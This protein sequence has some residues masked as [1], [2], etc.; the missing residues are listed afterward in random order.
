MLAKT[1]LPG[2]SICICS[3]TRHSFIS[4]RPHHW[5]GA[6]NCPFEMGWSEQAS[7]GLGARPRKS[8]GLWW[9]WKRHWDAE[10]I[11]L[12]QSRISVW[13][14]LVAETLLSRQKLGRILFQHWIYLTADISQSG[15]HSFDY[16]LK[17]WFPLQQ[18]A[19]GVH[20]ANAV[21]LT[22]KAADVGTASNDEDGVALAI[23]E[24]ILKPRGLSLESEIWWYIL[25]LMTVDLYRHHGLRLGIV[26]E[27]CLT[28]ANGVGV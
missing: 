25:W 6:A 11:H 12:A 26:K 19:I 28:V 23:E 17:C 13:V 22:M 14:I 7:G 9:W 16:H 10:G 2:V 8:Y 4:L 15:W 3:L 27:N 18:A 21:E 1:V 5:V 20:M 24:H